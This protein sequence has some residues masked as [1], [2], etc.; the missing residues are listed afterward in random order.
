MEIKKYYK[1]INENKAVTESD[2]RE[3]IREELSTSMDNLFIKVGSKFP[4]D[5][6][7]MSE[8]NRD[9]LDSLIEQFIDLY[10]N[11]TMDNISSFEKTWEYGSDKIKEGDIVVDDKGEEFFVTRFGVNN[12]FYDGNKRRFVSLENVRKKNMG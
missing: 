9:K 6:N 4:L 10:S 2:I 1:F 8:E 7:D 12:N 11:I 3:Y 5:N